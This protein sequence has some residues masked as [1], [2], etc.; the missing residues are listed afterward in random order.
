MF[1]ESGKGKWNRA[2]EGVNSSMI[3]LTHCKNFCKCYSVHT[4]AQH[5]K[6]VDSWDIFK[7]CI[8]VYLHFQ[9]ESRKLTEVKVNNT[10]I[11]QY[12]FYIW[13]FLYLIYSY[14]RGTFWEMC[15]WA[16]SLLHEHHRVYLS[17]LRKL[18]HH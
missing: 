17:K 14:R 4:P 15:C 6:D 10:F 9:K 12:F 8:H 11:L 1:Q 18:Q 13:I 5:N 16:T 7:E 3:Y 2:V